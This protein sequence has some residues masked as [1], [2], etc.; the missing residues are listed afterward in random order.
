MGRR[1]RKAAPPGPPRA[2]AAFAEQNKEP[3]TMRIGLL[4]VFV[5]F[6]LLELAL[7]IKVGQWIGFWLTML[8]LV[9]TAIIGS[10]VLHEQGFSAMRRMMQSAR[11]AR[12]PIEPVVDSVFLLIAGLLLLTPGLISDA[13]GCLLLVP[14]LRRA[15]ARW[16]VGHM[17][18]T[19]SVYVQTRTVGDAPGP[20]DARPGRDGADDG[21]VIEG[22]WER[23]DQPDQRR[24]DASSGSREPRRDP[25][26]DTKDRR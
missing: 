2:I 5:A 4:L 8:I 20:H 26:N 10:A 18:S 6:P 16:V 22:E 19:A 9:S 11:E 3:G 13:L 12:P 23:T 25:S 15:I 14:P 24:P 7:L 21:V 1:A 17:L